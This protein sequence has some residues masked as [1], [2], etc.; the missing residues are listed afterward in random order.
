M[1]VEVDSSFKL[2]RERA[3]IAGRGTK[4]KR[5]AKTTSAVGGPPSSA[6]ESDRVIT[7][8]A[9]VRRCPEALS[10]LFQVGKKEGSAA[11]RNSEPTASFLAGTSNLL[12]NLV[13]F[14]GDCMTIFI[15]LATGTLKR[16]LS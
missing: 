13:V 5:L 2:K 14:A 8:A 9:S 11:S 6:I 15:A 10:R 1:D 4:T 16:P 7:G 3:G 12:R